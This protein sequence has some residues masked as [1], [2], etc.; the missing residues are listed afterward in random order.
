L[1]MKGGCQLLRGTMEKHSPFHTHAPATEG[2]GSGWAPCKS[3]T[4]PH[5]QTHTHTHAN[6]YT[7]PHPQTHTHARTETCTHTHRGSER[8]NSLYCIKSWEGHFWS[9]TNDGTHPQLL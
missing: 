5:P 1:N 7:H 9:L 8:L 4:Q 2:P 3:H 6:M